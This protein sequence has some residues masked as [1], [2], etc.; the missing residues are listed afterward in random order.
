MVSWS[1]VLGEEGVKQMASYVKQ[2]G[3]GNADNHP[4]K[5]Q[6]DQFCFA[7]HGSD[8]SGN[9]MMG[10]PSLVDD[11]WLYGDSDAAIQQSIAMGRNGQMPAFGE[12]LDETQ[13]RLLV[14]LL[15]RNSSPR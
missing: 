8:G 1:Q 2:L 15:M 5:P 10:A 13:I 9:V 14:A 12:R 6:Y 11:I 3:K 7:C 4:G